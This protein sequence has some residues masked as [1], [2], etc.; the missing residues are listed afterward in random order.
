MWYCS[1]VNKHTFKR[2]LPALAFILFLIPIV[3]SSLLD[4]E[5]KKA[6]QIALEKE[7]AEKKAEEDAKEK[8]YLTG[9]FDP[10]ER[11]DFVL[12]PAE[13]SLVPNKIYLRKETYDAYIQ[14]R[15]AALLD[16]IELNL[17]S[18]TR[19]F[20]YQKDLWEKKWNGTTAVEGKNLS[21]SI[22]DG[23]ER[24]E[25]IL[26]YSAVPGTSRHH[27]G[28]DIDINDATLEYFET[29]KGEKVYEWLTENAS[30]FGF[31]QTYNPKGP[32][33]QTGY[34][35]EK[36]H[37]SYLPLSRNFT[38]EYKKLIKSEDIEGFLGDEYVAEENLINNYVL[39]INPDCI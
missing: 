33:R 6:N 38:Q 25:K 15:N 4:L 27:W 31:C 37:W 18:A 28:T 7:Q 30:L 26:E 23:K 36:W 34:N 2:I 32:G 12:V 39:S 10:A 3:T 5:Q 19:N 1:E 11:D 8:I 24:F 13:Y 14:M 20:D 21:K 29:P 22:T 16:N 35:E 17:A 9:K